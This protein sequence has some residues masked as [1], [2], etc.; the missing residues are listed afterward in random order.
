[1]YCNAR[2]LLNKLEELKILCVD[3]Q[4]DFILINETWG[5]K[6]LDNAFFSIPG[7]EVVGR[8]DRKDTTQG[9]GGGLIIYGS[10]KIIGNVSEF[11]SHTLDNFN[12]CS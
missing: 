7:F 5:Y 3:E 9:I 2:S 10:S 1:M 8:N 6:E 11:S 12:Q 4:P